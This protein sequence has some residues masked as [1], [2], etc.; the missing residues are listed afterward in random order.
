MGCGAVPVGTRD[1]ADAELDT[2]RPEESTISFGGS[3]IAP[4]SVDFGT[5][6]I[7]QDATATVTLTNT[8]ET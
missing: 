4:G 5:V 1:K 8:D 6:P 3:E 2:G 7:G